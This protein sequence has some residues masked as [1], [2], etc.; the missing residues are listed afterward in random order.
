MV[1]Y[2]NTNRILANISE[3]GVKR[4]DPKFWH[5]HP[6]HELTRLTSSLQLI[7]TSITIL[8]YI[9]LQFETLIQVQMISLGCIYFK[10]KK[11]NLT[12]WGQ[13]EQDIVE[14]MNIYCKLTKLKARAWHKCATKNYIQVQFYWLDNTR[15]AYVLNSVN[16]TLLFL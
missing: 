14:V 8:N 6:V 13:K 1:C 3:S 12:N 10:K 7:Y 5:Y 2:T 15:M 4:E 11:N 9:L 16:P